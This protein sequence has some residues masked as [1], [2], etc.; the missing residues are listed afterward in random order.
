MSYEDVAAETDSPLGT[1]ASR[2]GRVRGRV[3]KA[4]ERAGWRVP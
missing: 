2:I 1:V 3:R 4:C